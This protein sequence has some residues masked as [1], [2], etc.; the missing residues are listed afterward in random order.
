[1]VI[2]PLTKNKAPAVPKGTNWQDYKGEANTPLVGVMIPKGVLIIDIDS[3]K[4]VELSDINA[5]LGCDLDWQGSELQNT[6]N[7]GTH[8]AFR[9]PFES[10]LLNG[11]N[12]LG[13]NGFDT[14]SAL[15]GYIATGEGYENLTF[16]DSVIEAL[17]DVEALP[18]LPG[19]AIKKLTQQELIEVEDD[20]LSIVVSE[21]LELTKDEVSEYINLLSDEHAE[22]QDS[23]LKVGMALWHQ[24]GED[25]WELFDSFSQRSEEK[26]D[27]DK[28][29]RR[30]ESFARKQHKNPVTFATVIG[31]AGGA[32]AKSKII[33]ESVK[34]NLE[35]VETLDEMRE[36]M[37]KVAN[38]KMDNL[39]L[40][41]TLKKLQSKYF[42]V[43]GNK[44][45]IPA[46]KKELKA[47][48]G[49]DKDGDFVDEY[50]FLSATAEYMHRENKT[51][52]GPRAFDVK[53]GRDTPLTSEGEKQSATMFAN[54]KIEVV[55]NYM[56][57]PAADEVFTHNGLDY[58]NTYRE[59]HIKKPL[60]EVGAVAKVKRHLE[61]LLP[62]AQERE[63]VLNYLAYNVQ[64]PGV[65]M[66]WS[67]VLQGVQ[68]DGKSLLAEMMQ[69]VMGFD[70]VRI[71]N[72]QTLESSFT[73]WATGQCMTF[74]EELKL[75]N[76]RKY[77]VLNNLKPYI[78]NPIV[79]EHKK[80]KDP[81]SVINTTNYFALTN[82]KDAIPIDESDRR[83]CIL[84]SQWQQKDKLKAFMEENPNY[85][86][87]LYESVRT[88]VYEIRQWLLSHDIPQA[89]RM[90][91]RAPDTNAKKLMTELS[92]SPAVIC[93][94]EAIEEFGEQCT[95]IAGELDVTYLCK[96]VKNASSFDDRY[97][98][99]PN[100][101]ALKNALLNI[102]YEMVGRFRTEFS[103]NNLKHIVY[104][105]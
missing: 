9:V 78:S 13:V 52:C 15:K 41:V 101:G 73:G 29:R 82:F 12:L 1:M 77:E 57:F 88:G 23:W 59:P 7:G 80:G 84:F 3:Y 27:H 20:F 54:D 17:E 40:D 45:S 2:F 70:N 63:I 94:E 48:R 42:E 30:W 4:G 8:Y 87:D 31:L 61:H 10:D 92:K 21:P 47:L 81:R 72:V 58:L 93:L 53:H 74:I 105:R 60:K 56:Y 24:L 79:E 11:T 103:D 14:R 76:F 90:L 55:E 62:D 83:Y 25:G 64:N 5:A 86:P 91:K 35:E 22:D 85:Y 89:F 51:I 34:R 95:T 66:N 98:Q 50:V 6:L 33:T 69:H 97:E 43:T 32:K 71:M 46:I 68:G 26:Y 44:P 104:K 67:I 102:G 75:D 38:V 65:K 96:L 49:D 19:E 99:M 18:E 39:E 100:T 36:Q 37:T 16:N 28:N